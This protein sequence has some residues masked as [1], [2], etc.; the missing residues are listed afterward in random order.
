MRVNEIFCS[1]QGEGY[2]TGTAAVFVR[3]S[4]CNL[5]CPFCDTDFAFSTNYGEKEIASIISEYGPV[6]HVVLTGGEPLLQITGTFLDMLHAQGNYI[7][8]ETNGTVGVDADVLRKIDWVTCSPKNEMLQIGRIDEL[9]VVYDGQDIS[10]YE[11]LPIYKNAVKYLQPCDWNDDAK[12]RENIEGAV[13][14][15]KKNPQWRMSL[16]TQKIIRVK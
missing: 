15:I 4:G 3:F 9:K 12:N 13:S 5:R 2:Y 10:R 6:K 7:Q 8:V 11:T 1:L 14:T 16:Q